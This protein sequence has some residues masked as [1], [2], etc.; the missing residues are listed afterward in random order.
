MIVL[1]EALGCFII[2]GLPAEALNLHT[3]GNSNLRSGLTLDTEDKQTT[4]PK[5]HSPN[6]VKEYC[7]VIL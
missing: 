7:W 6:S 2:A 1:T 5:P 3:T 4:T